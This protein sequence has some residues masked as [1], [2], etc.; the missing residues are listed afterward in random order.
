VSESRARD[1]DGIADQI[2]IIN[3]IMRRYMSMGKG[4]D[5]AEEVETVSVSEVVIQTVSIYRH[6]ATEAGMTLT[7]SLHGE[8]SCGRIEPGK[9]TQVL[10][11]LIKNAARHSRGKRILVSGE[12]MPGFVRLTVSDDGCGFSPAP[13]PGDTFPA[14]RGGGIGLAICRQIVDEC[15]GELTIQSDPGAG[16]EVSFT[17]PSYP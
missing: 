17:I 16:T 5:S 6:I 2:Q 8:L 1:L 3:D 15:G 13:P 12:D 10:L 9:L 7:L 4:A 14:K 11:N